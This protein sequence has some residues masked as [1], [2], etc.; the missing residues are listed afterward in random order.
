[1]KAAI[2]DRF[3]VPEEVLQVREVPTPEPGRGEVRVRM[4]RQPD[5]PVRPAGGPRRVRQAAHLARDARLRGRRRRR[6]VRRRADRPAARPEAGQAR[7]GPQR[8]PAATGQSSPSS[9]PARS[10]PVPDDLP[11]EQAAA[12]FVNPAS[13]LAMTRHVL[14]VPPGD[15]LLQ[16]AA[17]SALGRMVI[18]LGKHFGFRTINVVPPPRT[19]G[20]VAARRR[21]R[22]HLHGRRVDPEARPRPDRGRGREVRHRRG[23]RR[24]AAR[25]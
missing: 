5:Q 1:M 16:T 8:G 15:W 13:A 12:F 23:R 22:G 9:R 21:R 11:D 14:K 7:G 2:F 25:R 10:C 20:G 4:T 6:Q 17:G 24:D 3:G 19:G 18:R